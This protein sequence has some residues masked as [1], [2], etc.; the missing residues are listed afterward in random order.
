[1][2]FAQE[3]FLEEKIGRTMM[4][5][6]TKALTIL[7]SR[8]SLK[9]EFWKKETQATPLLEPQEGKPTY[10]LTPS[11]YEASNLQNAMENP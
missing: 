4:K 3:K 8:E 2:K 6:R 5:I 11:F 1:V 7:V 10:F 9:K